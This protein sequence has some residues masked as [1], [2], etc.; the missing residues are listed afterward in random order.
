MA[1]IV[2][3]T[4]GPIPAGSTALYKVT[5]VQ[6]DGT[7]ITLGM[8]TTVTL[9]ICDTLTG[10]IINDCDNVD[11]F[12]TGRGS[13]SSDG[14]L[15]VQLLAGDTAVAVPGYGAYIVNRTLVINWT[16]NSGTLASAHKFNFQIAP[17][18][19]P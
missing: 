4:N 3:D 8:L 17:M 2:T 5:F 13:V 10:E 18:D 12:N 6:S 15:S 9:T 7:P 14:V 16:Y 19:P 1:A 11:I